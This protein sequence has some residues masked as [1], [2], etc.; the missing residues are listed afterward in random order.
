M[1]TIPDFSDNELKIV[2]DTLEER[3]GEVIE[4][5]SADAYRC[6]QRAAGRVRR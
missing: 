5:P 4:P 6:L 3:H 2:G 1:S